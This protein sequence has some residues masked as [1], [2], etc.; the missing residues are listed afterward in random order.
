MA[1][2]FLAVRAAMRAAVLV[3]LPL[4]AGAW[5][6]VSEIERVGLGELAQLELDEDPVGDVLKGDA[7]A[8]LGVLNGV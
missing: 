4:S 2:L 5:V 7:A 8:Y 1:G 6:D 3:G